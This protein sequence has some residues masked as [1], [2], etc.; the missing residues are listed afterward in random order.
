MA[1]ITELSS[2][3][4]KLTRPLTCPTWCRTAPSASDVKYLAL[5]S[6]CRQLPVP[7]A[8]TQYARQPPDPHPQV[9]LVYI[10]LSVIL[11]VCETPFSHLTQMCYFLSTEQE[12]VLQSC[13]RKRRHS[14]DDNP[15]EIY[16]T[17]L[18]NGG[19]VSRYKLSMAEANICKRI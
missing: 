8:S 18:D 6:I 15:G 4:S 10:I 9:I 14:S 12:H 17:S 13:S 16:S 5:P 19:D 3:A 11:Y 7:S 1:L 2:M